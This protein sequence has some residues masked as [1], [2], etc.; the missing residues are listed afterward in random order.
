MGTLQTIL[1]QGVIA[2]DVLSFTLRVL[3]CMSTTFFD[4]GA[5]EGHILDSIDVFYTTSDL[6]YLL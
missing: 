2:G 5:I 3:D 4:R 6:S 1:H